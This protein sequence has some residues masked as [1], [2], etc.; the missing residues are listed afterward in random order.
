MACVGRDPSLQPQVDP[1]AGWLGLSMPAGR[2]LLWDDQIALARR[3]D[4]S[5]ML[6]TPSVAYETCAN[7]AEWEQVVRAGGEGISMPPDWSLERCRAVGD[8]PCPAMALITIFGA[9]R[10]WG[11]LPLVSRSWSQPI[12]GGPYVPGPTRGQPADFCLKR[13]R[14]V[15]ETTDGSAGRNV[16][17]L[18]L[19]C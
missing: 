7:V 12:A 2:V 17:E 5:T 13:P 11:N 8:I 18:G 6:L 9:A 10:S 3:E 4:A 14:F 15:N 19:A 1:S 16:L